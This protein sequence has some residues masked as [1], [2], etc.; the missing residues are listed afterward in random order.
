MSP[1]NVSLLVLAFCLLLQCGDVKPNPG[2]TS[3]N[4]GY[5]AMVDCAEELVSSLSTDPKGFAISLFSKRLISPHVLEQTNELNETNTEKAGRPYTEVLK[6]VQRC[7]EEYKTFVGRLEDRKHC[8]DIV[9]KLGQKYALHEEDARRREVIP[10]ESENGGAIVR[11]DSLATSVFSSPPTSPMSLASSLSSSLTGT[12]S[13]R[14][15]EEKVLNALR[16]SNL[17]SMEQ[18]FSDF[19][20][21]I[22][23]RFTEDTSTHNIEK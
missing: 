11:S 4:A 14:S 9:Q 10:H 19:T 6:I 20:A 8:N 17:V 21:R 18:Y 12:I 22:A 7:L 16:K 2:P 1:L 23:K 5:E 15:S 3:T 13:M